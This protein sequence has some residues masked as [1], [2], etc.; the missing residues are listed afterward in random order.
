M[1]EVVKRGKHRVAL[2]FLRARRFP[3][4]RNG[5]LTLRSRKW[6]SIEERE[7]AVSFDRTK[8]E[9]QEEDLGKH[10]SPDCSLARNSLPPIIPIRSS[11]RRR[12]YEGITDDKEGDSGWLKA[13][14]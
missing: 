12:D 1:F 7:P 2:H 10:L 3:F 6:N 13:P 11:S 9:R 8:K 14:R 5:G 4:I